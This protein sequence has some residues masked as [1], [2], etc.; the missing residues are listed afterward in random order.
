MAPKREMEWFWDWWRKKFR[1]SVDSKWIVP[2]SPSAH[3]VRFSS[4]GN[5]WPVGK[6]E[7][8]E[9]TDWI[10]DNIGYELSK[11]W[12]G[13]KG[14]LKEGKGDCEDYC[15]TIISAILSAGD[16][17]S[18]LVVGYVNSKYVD[19][20][21]HVWVDHNGGI[22]DATVP[23]NKDL[24]V[25]YEPVTKWRIRRE[26]NNVKITENKRPSEGNTVRQDDREGFKEL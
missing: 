16:G 13:P 24:D 12:L 4:I 11:E 7:A 25:S 21:P 20:G 15:F 23:E 19:D 6:G 2:E 9:I 14:L 26:K 17:E 10:R 18:T 3:Y 1:Q 22:F 5:E 8:Q